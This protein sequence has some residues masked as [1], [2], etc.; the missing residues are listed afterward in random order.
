MSTFSKAYV[1][2]TNL[3]EILDEIKKYYIIGK[4]ETMNEPKSWYYSENGNETM[5]LSNNYNKSWCEIELEF[6]FST[7]L[8]DEFLRRLS[9][10]FE[11]VILLGYYQSTIGNGRI[12][13][14]CKGR[15]ELSIAQ[16]YSSYDGFE[17]IYL[18]DNFGVSYPIKKEFNIPRLG[19]DFNAI[20]YELIN[21]F[22][23]NNDLFSDNFKS[24]E[25]WSYLHLEKINE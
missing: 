12:A 7:Y 21:K 8:Y 25:D 13:R 11:T 24:Y 20:D 6:N 14:F 9:E 1:R 15:L 3:N 18:T 16:Y 22:F 17:K 10:K 5:I 4:N 23:K 19:E 2:L